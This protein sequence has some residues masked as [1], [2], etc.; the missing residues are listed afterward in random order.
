MWER[1]R[2]WLNSKTLKLKELAYEKAQ[3]NFSDQLKA[4]QDQVLRKLFKKDIL[5]LDNAPWKEHHPSEVAELDSD[6]LSLTTAP[7]DM[8][9][10][11]EVVQS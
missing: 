6:S 3:Q 11:E 10:E 7:E 1:F 2:K 8:V 9:V 5:S 4:F